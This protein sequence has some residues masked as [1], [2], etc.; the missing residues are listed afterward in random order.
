ML[1]TCPSPFPPFPSL[2][3]ANLPPTLAHPAAGANKKKAASAP[4]GTWLDQLKEQRMQRRPAGAAGRRAG[5]TG[6]DGAAGGGD[7]SPGGK[8]GQLPVLYKYHEG[9]TNAVKRPLLMRDLL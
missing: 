3:H 2:P 5:S 4:R 9:Y 6:G 8:R 7:T 1:C